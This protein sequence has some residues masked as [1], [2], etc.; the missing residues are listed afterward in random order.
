LPAGSRLAN[1]PERAAEVLSDAVFDQ[2]GALTS[3][4]ESVGVT[5]LHLAIGGLAA[6]PAV[7]SVIAGA[8]R[9]DQV[10]ANAV[11]GVWEP[12]DEDLSAIDRI[13]PGPG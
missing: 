8:T 3:Y 10:R 5:L 1:N 7:A 11:A 9:P 12:S 13:V 6:Q 4:A 2:V